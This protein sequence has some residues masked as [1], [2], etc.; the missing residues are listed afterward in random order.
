[1]RT[2]QQLYYLTPRQFEKEVVRILHRNGYDVQETDYV[3][4][5][6]I[7][8]LARKDG[9]TYVV[10]VKKYSD[11]NL[12][13]RPELQKLQGAM[14]YQQADRAMFITLGFF[15]KP[16]QEYGKKQG[17]VLIDGNELMKMATWG[18]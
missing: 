3:G 9:I 14:L 18:K 8:A 4:D 12:V 15:S 11:T 2:R 7:D 16:A 5:Y 1:I 10:Q 17:I 6:G 13:G